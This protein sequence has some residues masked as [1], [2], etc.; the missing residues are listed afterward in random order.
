MCRLKHFCKTKMGEGGL[1]GS[2]MK[3]R[4]GSRFVENCC[5]FNPEPRRFR[6]PGTN[7]QSATVEVTVWCVS[8]V[9]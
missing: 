3:K 4:T 5:L 6:S 1:A 9:P 8:I 2:E 7:R